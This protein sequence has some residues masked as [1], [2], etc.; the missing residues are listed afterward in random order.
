MRV[1]T[2][3]RGLLLGLLLAAACATSPAVAEADTIQA[4]RYELVERA[5]TIDVEVDRGFATLVVTRTVQNLGLTSDQATFWLELPEAAVATRLR[6][7]AV[8]AGGQ[9]QWF[10]GELMEAEAAAAKYH[11][12]TGVGGYYPK[13]P[14]LLSWRSQGKLALQV[15]PVPKQG[16]K[17]VEYTLKIPLA[18]A[19]GRYR[20]TLSRLGTEDLAA[21]VRARPAH[22]EDALTVNGIAAPASASAK[23]ELVLELV[24]HAPGALAVS[25]ASV[26][27]GA[28]RHLVHG[29]VEAA[30]HVAEAPRNA[31]VVIVFDSSRS[32]HEAASALTMVRSYLASMPGATVELLT[33]DR[34][35]KAPLGHALTVADAIGKLASFV[36]TLGNGSALDAA[37]TEADSLLAASSALPSARRVVVVTDRLTRSELT[38]ARLGAQRW[39]SGALLHLATVETGRPSLVRDEDAEW[40]V[41]PRRTGGLAWTAS[42]A[43]TVDGTSRRVFEELARPKRIDHLAVNGL[44]VPLDVPDSLAE[45]EGLDAYALAAQ[46]TSRLEVTGELWSTPLHVTAV[47]GD[48]QNRRA[49]A[50]VFGSP[51]LD[52]LSEPEQMTLALL[53]RAVSPVTSYLAIEPGV[54]PS[55]EGLDPELEGFGEGGGGMGSGIGLGSMGSIGHGGGAARAPWLEDAI[56]TAAR[57]CGG[58]A[59]EA[60]VL[61][62]TTRD[63]IVDVRRVELRPGR[64]GKAEACLREAVWGFVL[65]SSFVTSFEEHDVTSKL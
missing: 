64:D 24:P 44:T 55:T 31:H 3:V 27:M 26:P 63:E 37:L 58:A 12:L 20:V 54:R 30:P 49:A 60:S 38:P 33:F 22:R 16:T 29:R 36:P 34:R 23:G 41:L 25:L 53:G 13:D 59:S 42:A 17:T 14:A 61:L 45:G 9:V 46:G 18:Y 51:L 52:Q 32:H 35:V 47:P 5:H 4:T 8:T 6:T 10:E 15:F 65:P 43:W 21:T 28:A 62:E 57:R 48:E 2:S 39:K 56:A 19:E 50:H 11:E 7:S 40:A 1:A